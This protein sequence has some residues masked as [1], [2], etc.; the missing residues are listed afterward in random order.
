MEV[1][2][3]IKVKVVY[4]DMNDELSVESVWATKD[5]E[6]Y[7]VKNIPFFAPNL[8][9]NYLIKVELD[10]GEYFFEDI[11]QPSKHSTIQIVLFQTSE[12]SRIVS[13]IEKIKC[14]W[15]GMYEQKILAVDIPPEID[16]SEV[17]EFLNI[18]KDK[19]VLDFKEACLRGKCSKE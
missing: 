16:Y 3:D 2:D 8:A 13:F 17:K 1:D 4:Y 10:D 9:Y 12:T 14:N 18:E 7:Y 15:E 11:I 6:F 5:G 19:L